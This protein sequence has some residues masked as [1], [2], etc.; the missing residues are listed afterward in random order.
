MGY[1]IIYQ[2]EQKLKTIAKN[3]KIKL[4]KQEIDEIENKYVFEQI[5]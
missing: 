3:L 1:D 4:Y 5:I 2:D